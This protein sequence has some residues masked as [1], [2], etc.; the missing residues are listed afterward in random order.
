M[1][2]WK[3]APEGRHRRPVDNVRGEGVPIVGAVVCGEKAGRKESREG[4]NT[5]NGSL[6]HACVQWRRRRRGEGGREGGSDSQWIPPCT[7][8]TQATTQGEGWWCEGVSVEGGPCSKAFGGWAAPHLASI[9][10][11]FH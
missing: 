11:C 4:D 5:S 6:S 1:R 10:E 7:S 9:V 2:E 8:V 3:T